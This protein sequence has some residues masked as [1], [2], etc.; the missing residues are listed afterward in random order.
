MMQAT[1]QGVKEVVVLLRPAGG[2]TQLA[3]LVIW[4]ETVRMQ[5]E[6]VLVLLYLVSAGGAAILLARPAWARLRSVRSHCPD[7]G[8]AT[9]PLRPPLVAPLVGR[10]THPRWCMGC[11]WQG[12][13]PRGL[14]RTPAVEPIIAEPVDLRLRAVDVDGR[15]VEVML[16]CR[17][18][19][20]HWFGRLGYR[21]EDWHWVERCDD[22]EGASLGDLI[23]QSL[24]LSEPAIARR[25][26]QAL[27]G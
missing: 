2:G 3:R 17:P 8:G 20:L 23:E 1:G 9:E 4:T 5:M 15:R 26:R 6:T 18:E 16:Q 12:W 10:I 14:A 11:G 25:V 27:Y 19:S 7:C 13:V 22:F 24:T 21:A